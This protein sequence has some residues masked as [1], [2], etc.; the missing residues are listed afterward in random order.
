[1]DVK[2]QTRILKNCV[3]LGYPVILEDANETFDPI[4]EPLLGKQIEKKGNMWTIKI[5]DE[6]IEYSRDFKFYVTT[7][8]SKPH[9]SPEVCVK[10][11]MLNFQVTEVGLEDQMLNIVVTHEDPNNMKKRNDA[12]IKKAD[13]M[14]KKAQLED[15][16]LNQIA[17]SEVDILEDDVLVE[18]LDESKSQCKLIDQQL[19]EAEQI[20]KHIENVRDQ[21]KPVAFRVSRLFFVLVQMMNVDP[22][23]QY[24]LDFYKMIYER[25]LD[26]G[27][28]IEK[29][30][31]NEK[32]KFFIKEFT[33]LLYENICRSLFE[34]HKLLFSMLMLFK[35]IEKTVDDP[36]KILLDARD[37][38]FMMV[39][40]SRVEMSRPNPTGEGGWMTDKMW[41]SI[42]QI[43]EE[44]DVFK[45]L[46]SNVERNLDE[47]E[48]IY[49]LQQPQETK[50]AKWPAPYGDMPLLKIAMF[51]RV[52]RP[53]KV[54]PIIKKMIVEDKEL[55]PSYIVPPPFDMEKSYSD[56]TN[57]VPIIIVLSPGADPMNELQKLGGQ[58]R[59]K[60]QAIS[61]GQGQA[62]IAK[63]SIQFAIENNEWVVLQNCHLCPSFM[64]TL[65]GIIDN[66]VEDKNSGFRMWL[67]SMPSPNFPVTILQNGVKAT[68]E[69]PKGL[70]ANMLRSYLGIDE[71]EF[72]SCDK[73]TAYKALM[74]GLCFFNA[75]I[76]ERRKFGPLGWNIPY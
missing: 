43:S 7:K 25:A 56:S 52:F 34:E 55:G 50:E 31:R 73:P 44:F 60:I 24:S 23:Y 47:W 41:A 37:V 74:W 26:N 15:K 66:I 33:S 57:K 46:A 11:T 18:T 16:I 14:I 68:I 22:M 29:G 48:R 51:L 10:V 39:G 6:Q 8:L 40:G 2:V 19:I 9:F 70:K 30:K 27:N 76:L 49:N 3:S 36:S 63:N 20:M 32:V 5:G 35:I 12:I 65:E 71:S 4:I 61:L 67:T 54:I 59:A 38:R 53:D 17:T 62:E 45:D 58:Y 28:S 42:L 72:E 1:M 69:P 21:F 13:N 75:L 64:P